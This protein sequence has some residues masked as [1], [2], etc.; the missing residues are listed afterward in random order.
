M[1]LRWP[2]HFERLVLEHGDATVAHAC[3]KGG[4]Q[5]SGITAAGAPATGEPASGAWATGVADAERQWLHDH[6][7]DWDGTHG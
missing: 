5:V 3:A 7:I 2:P 1:L 4:E 6:G